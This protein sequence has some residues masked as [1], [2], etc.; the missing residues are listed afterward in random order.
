MEHF[1]RN[2]LLQGAIIITPVKAEEPMTSASTSGVQAKKVEM[3][4]T[5]ADTNS[6]AAAVLGV[7]S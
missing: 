2:L 1:T 6:S 4:M 5:S 7:S 3:G